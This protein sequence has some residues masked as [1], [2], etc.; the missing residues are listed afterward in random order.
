MLLASYVF[1]A[2]WN[3][4][5]VLLLWIST[6]TDWFAARRMA[7]SEGGRK[8][9]YLLLSIAVNLG[10]LGY[11][12]YGQFIEANFLALMSS[13]GVA[14]GDSKYRCRRTLN[15]RN[16]ANRPGFV[17]GHTFKYPL[18]QERLDPCYFI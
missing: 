8:R 6:L 18:Y 12:K 2:A 14:Y 3:P 1:Y 10:L 17:C 4:P 15:P 7:T 16:H 13:L 11:F 5:F 9:L